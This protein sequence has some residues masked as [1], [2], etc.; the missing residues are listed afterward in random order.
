MRCKPQETDVGGTL[1]GHWAKLGG[2][3]GIDGDICFAVL[4]TAMVNVASRGY[5]C[6]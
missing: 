5:A 6:V 1:K 3:R 4:V 2:E